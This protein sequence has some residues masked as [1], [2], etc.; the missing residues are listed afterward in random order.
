M[1]GAAYMQRQTVFS[2]SEFMVPG[3][4]STGVE[5][6]IDL[7]SFRSEMGRSGYEA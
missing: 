7:E 6:E 4:S 3:Y 1:I 5:E 2:T